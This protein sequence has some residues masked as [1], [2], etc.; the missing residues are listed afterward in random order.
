MIEDIKCGDRVRHVSDRARDG[1]R[2]PGT[3]TL[4]SNKGVCIR[5][6]RPGPHNEAYYPAEWFETKPKHIRIMKISD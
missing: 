6:D 1:G 3:V 5:F 4:I 2:G